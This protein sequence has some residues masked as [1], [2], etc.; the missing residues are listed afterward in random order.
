LEKGQYEKAI[1]AI[2]KMQK[3]Y[4]LSF[5]H[6]YRAEVYPRGFSLLGEIYERQGDEKRAIES[7]EK[8]LDLW[9]D[10]DE[11]LPELIEAKARL[12]RLHGE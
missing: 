7:Y 5:S 10:A 1:E 3:T 6:Y 11:D 9:K 12:A 8:F 4:N 2:R